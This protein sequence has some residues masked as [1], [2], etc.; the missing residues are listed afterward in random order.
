MEVDT[1]ILGGAI[2]KTNEKLNIGGLGEVNK[3]V[4]KELKV[5]ESNLFGLLL[6]F[7]R[8]LTP[9]K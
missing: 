7:N 8:S 5:Y 9:K 6:T 3:I 2:N 4:E 1:G